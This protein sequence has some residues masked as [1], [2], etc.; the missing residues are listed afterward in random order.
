MLPR[1]GPCHAVPRHTSEQRANMPAR[2]A[3]CGRDVQVLRAR[4]FFGFGTWE[5]LASCRVVGL[6]R[7]HLGESRLSLGEGW[8][9]L[10]T[11]TRSERVGRRRTLW[12]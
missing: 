2:H 1:V 12:Q 5:V 8:S 11:L 4:T 10:R 7:P 6:H 3:V 9:F